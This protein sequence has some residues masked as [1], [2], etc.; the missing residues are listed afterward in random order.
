MEIGLIAIS[1]NFRRIGEIKIANS[2]AANIFN[3]NKEEFLKVNVNT[4]M[5]SLISKHHDDYL[6]AFI[7]YSGRKVNTDRRLLL[8]KKKENYIF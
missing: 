8:G 3:Y 5:P 6:K 7:S 2:Q 4:L 1:L